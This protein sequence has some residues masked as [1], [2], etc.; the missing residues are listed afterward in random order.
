MPTI[1]ISYDALKQELGKELSL[2][3]LHQALFDMG[4]ELTQVED[5]MLAVEITAERLDLLSLQG[6]ARALRAFL[7]L[8]PSVPRY[9]VLD[10]DENYKVHITNQVKDVRPYTVCAIVKNLSL[11]EEQIEQIIDVQEKLH[12]TLGRGRARGA[13]GI[14]PLATITLPITYTADKPEHIS[15]VPLGHTTEMTAKQI[16][17]Q[18]ET[19]KEYAHLLEGKELFPYFIDAKGEILSVPPIINSELTGRVTAQTTELFI[20]CSGFDKLLLHQL[21][22]N[23]ACLFADMGGDIYAM[24]LT[25]ENGA[26]EQTPVLSSKKR[27]F[28][29]K[30]LKKYIGLTLSLEELKSLLRK[31][32][33]EFVDAEYKDDNKI[34]LHVTA[35]AYREDLWHEIDIIEDVARAYGYNNLPLTFPTVAGIGSVLPLSALKEELA[36]V[37][38]GMGFIETYTFALTSKQ[39]QLTYMRLAE[40]DIAFM[41]VANGNETQTMLRISLL[42][43]QL[44][45]LM[46]NRNETLPQKIFEASFV[47]IPDKTKDVKCRNELHLAA[48][49]TDKQVTFTQ[50]RQVLEALLATRN[51]T[52]RIT[53]VEHPSF[54]S[55]RAG[56]VY[57]NDKVIGVIGQL[58]PEVLTHFGIVTPVVAFEI[59]LEAIHHG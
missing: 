8:S 39:E 27:S 40:E 19:G 38:V 54:I 22:T 49:I 6:L 43:E 4:M 33:Y 32:M 1:N 20:E 3:E 23:L 36:N 55:G 59:N 5:D 53:A 50:L 15:F 11:S 9:K 44:K 16:L 45:C 31:M 26:T 28:S 37:L 24:Q 12:A 14:Y 52:I 58:H 34:I 46:H 7:G 48:L 21:L 41:P 13:I 10:G 2:E 30:T 42:P 56:A 25:Y 35:P 57:L 51:E 47:V 29:T 17:S 18:H